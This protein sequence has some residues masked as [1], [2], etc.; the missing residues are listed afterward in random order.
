MLR[1]GSALRALPLSPNLWG[2]QRDTAIVWTG[3]ERPG[4][5]QL[6]GGLAQFG[7]AGGMR[8]VKGSN[9][10]TPCKANQTTGVVK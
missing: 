2:R 6:C 5:F 4:R 9:P 3:C 8:Q 10:L 1:F 7:R